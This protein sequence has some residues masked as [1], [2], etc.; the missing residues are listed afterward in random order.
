M[1]VELQADDDFDIEFKDDTFNI[2][3][4]TNLETSEEGASLVGLDLPNIHSP[5]LRIECQLSLRS[6]VVVG[7][8][9]LRGFANV[10]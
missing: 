4:D 8:N 3:L 6:L 9:T 10:Y 7:V 1:D 2:Q 5:R